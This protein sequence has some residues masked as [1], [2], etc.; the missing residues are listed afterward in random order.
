ML[1]PPVYLAGSQVPRADGIVRHLEG[2]GPE[3]DESSIRAQDDLKLPSSNVGEE[4]GYE[5]LKTKAGPRCSVATF[6][7]SRNQIELF[8]ELN[9]KNARN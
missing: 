3:V 9:K 1:L 2:P 4:M 6:Y 5:S 8:Q 7:F